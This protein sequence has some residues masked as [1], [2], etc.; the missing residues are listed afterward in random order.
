MT[1]IYFLR[2]AGVLMGKRPRHRPE[3]NIQMDLKETGWEG[4]DRI[5]LIENRST[6]WAVVETALCRRVP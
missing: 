2:V 3:D 1:F 6:W 4:V 5:H